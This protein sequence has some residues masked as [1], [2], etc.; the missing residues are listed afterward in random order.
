MNKT[1]IIGITTSES[2]F[3]NYLE[4]IAGANTPLSIIQLNADKQNTDDVKRCDGILLS[5]GI[6]VTPAFYNST[7]ERYPHAP[8]DGWKKERDIFEMKIFQLAREHKIPVLGICRGLQLINVA[9]GGTL[10]PDLEE[11]GKLDHKRNNAIDGIHQVHITENS[12]LAK[13]TN[14]LSG[15]V[16]SA[17]HQAVAAVSEQL[18][19]CAISPDAV[20]ESLAWKDATE[21]SPLLAVQWHPE[22][23]DDKENNPLSENIRNWFIKAA[24][25]YANEYH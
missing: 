25:D 15:I 12:F 24:V 13:E 1:I 3:N 20:I 8:K 23:M 21:K 14:V 7:R 4:W 11:A 16:N 2:R 5:G 22:R 17:H 6:D 19:V 18:S 10:I 9:L